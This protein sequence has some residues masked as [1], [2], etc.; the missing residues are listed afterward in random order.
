MA[1][2][3]R[4]KLRVGSDNDTLLEDIVQSATVSYC[5]LK[6]PYGGFPV[7]ANGEVELDFIAEDW[8]L[9]AAIEIFAKLGA[10]G[11]TVHNENGVS[12][13]YETAAL[14]NTLKNE[15]RPIVGVASA[16]A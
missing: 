16:N 8:V 4:L 5:S 13:A 12:R 10:E 9:R 7:D 6:Y 2:L 14:S 11:Q 1:L 15:I 3:D